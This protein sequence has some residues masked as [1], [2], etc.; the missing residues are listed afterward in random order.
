MLVIPPMKLSRLSETIETSPILTIAAEI[1][2][3]KAAGENIHNLTVGDFDSRIFPIP[4]ALTEA[5]IEAYR[6]N[7]TNYPGAFGL[8]GI[9]QGVA[10]L[11]NRLCG[12]SYSAEDVIIASGSRPV[13]YSAY[14]AIVDQGDKVVFPVPSW[15]NEHYA[16]MV[17]A[18]VV[19]VDTTPENHFMP[20]AEALAPHLHDA[21]LLALCSPL[22]PTG[23]V[24]SKTDLKEICELVVE[25]N[26]SR[27]ADQKPLYV[28]FDQVYWMLTF[29]GVDF[30][31]PLKECPEI[32]PYAVFVDGMS[33]AF[34]GTGLRV[35][36]ATGS[37]AV[38]GKMVSI[39]AHA[40]A[41]APKP[42][43][44]AVGKYLCQDAFVDDH[45]KN[46]RLALGERLQGFFDRVYDVEGKGL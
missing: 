28:M 42:D 46:F 13:I 4:D 25:V 23:T 1:N 31:H 12:L 38:L 18:D 35:G 2:G 17:E 37:K 44:V 33:K 34:A 39:I 15:N 26:R 3:R 40:G 20:T 7:Q 6:H 27:S 9:R 5:T 14:R 45:L 22:N 30:H 16:R 10:G 21:I 36:W 24:L 32:E 41:W 19:T 8:P 11:L 43:Q 29:G